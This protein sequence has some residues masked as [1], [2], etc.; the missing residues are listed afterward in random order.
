MADAH[1][2]PRAPENSMTIHLAGAALTHASSLI[3]VLSPIVALCALGVSIWQFRT[4]RKHYELSS[5]PLLDVVVRHGSDRGVGIHLINHGL[6]PA[7]IRSA[8][9]T[10]GTKHY[11]LLSTSELQQLAGDIAETISTKIH[12]YDP[13]S[14][15]GPTT[16]IEVFW[17][18][19]PKAELTRL[20]VSENWIVD[21]LYTDLYQKNHTSRFQCAFRPQAVE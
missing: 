3:A 12:R 4:N 13:G 9:L 20:F 2:I 19:D 10:A 11:N 15:L 16:S 1:Q 8:R 7:I 5:Q 17:I 21:V 6:G 14:I 18:D